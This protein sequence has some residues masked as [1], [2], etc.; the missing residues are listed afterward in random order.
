MHTEDVELD[1]RLLTGRIQLGHRAEG[2]GTSIGAQDRDVPAGQFVG[3]TC[4]LR[5]IGEVH[6]ADLDRHPVP[7]G[8][9]GRHLLEHLGAA[10]GDDQMVAA[11]GEFVGQGLSDALGGTGD[12]GSAVGGWRGDWHPDIVGI[13]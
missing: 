13:G 11:G 2:R 8:D 10:R 5:R 7:F 4:P 3:Q 9:P 12:D 6:R 1:L